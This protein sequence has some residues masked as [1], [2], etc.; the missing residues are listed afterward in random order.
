MQSLDKAKEEID[1]IYISI[2]NPSE[3][4]IESIM[5]RELYKGILFP[6]QNSLDN[7]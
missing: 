7:G 6:E 4:S 2:K 1:R 5:K 3:Y